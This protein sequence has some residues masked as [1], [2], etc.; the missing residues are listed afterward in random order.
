VQSLIASTVTSSLGTLQNQAGTFVVLS[1]GG[2]T[3]PRCTCKN[4]AVPRLPLEVAPDAR[5]TAPG[6]ILFYRFFRVD[7]KVE[8]EDARRAGIKDLST[9]S[10][11]PDLLSWNI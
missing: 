7:E 10:A 5:I 8:P 6:R 2:A 4:I 9:G 1:S 3:Y 11:R